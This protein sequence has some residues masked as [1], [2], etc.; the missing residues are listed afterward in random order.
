MTIVLPL[1]VPL[2]SPYFGPSLLTIALPAGRVSNT[3]IPSVRVGSDPAWMTPF[4]VAPMTASPDPWTLSPTTPSAKQGYSL[5]PP[6]TKEDLTMDR[7]VSSTTF[8]GEDSKDTRSVV[9]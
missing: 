9:I 5:S 3:S 2:L 6:T 7:S 8:L 1:V 4:S